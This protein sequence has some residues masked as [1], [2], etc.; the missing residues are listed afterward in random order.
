M[1]D[2]EMEHVTSVSSVYISINCLWY[3]SNLVECCRLFVRS[4]ISA[5]VMESRKLFAREEKAS[6]GCEGVRFQI[7][8]KLKGTDCHVRMQSVIRPW[9]NA[10]THTHSR[11][12][13]CHHLALNEKIFKWR[14]EEEKR[15]KRHSGETVN[16]EQWGRRLERR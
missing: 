1:I 13:A 3:F 14:H 7:F 11:P 9:W 5:K 2:N 10:H 12:L 8:L 6:L 16:D 15:V 4:G